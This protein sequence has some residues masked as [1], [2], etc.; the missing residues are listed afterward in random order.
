MI[1]TRR[2]FSSSAI[3][4]FSQYRGAFSHLGQSNQHRHYSEKVQNPNSANYSDASGSEPVGKHPVKPGHPE[5]ARPEDIPKTQNF[6]ISDGLWKHRFNFIPEVKEHY[7]RHLPLITASNPD[8]Y[9]SVRESQPAYSPDDL[10]K[11]EN[12]P[13]GLVRKPQ[14]FG[15]RSALAFMNFLKIFTHAAFRERYNH[16]A[17][18]LE[19]IASVPPM[20]AAALR[21]F[22][23]LRNVKHDHGWVH[24]LLEEAENERVHLLT[25][26]EVTKPTFIE[27]MIVV[28]AQ[29][30]YTTF[31]TAAYLIS[32]KWCHRLTGYLEEEAVA[33]YTSYL[34]AIDQGICPN[35]PAP[36][37]AKKYWN[38]AD[39]ATIR[40]VVVCVRIDEAH[41]RDFN[42][43]VAD[44]I[45]RKDMMGASD[46]KS[47]V[48]G[49]I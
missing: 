37:I 34:Q 7:Y 2:L 28:L 17:I 27:R 23:S 42:H 15:D 49:K 25:W 4:S 9:K 38:L 6:E 12:L 33:A 21:H 26:M 18:T 47:N 20:V 40:D 41:H 43:E 19:T 35:G 29:I 39:D 22:D 11:L 1:T 45:S 24:M 36:E 8:I 31:Y 48:S 16:H 13:S 10:K 3:K 5:D 44:K 32:P 30:G 46:F 14:T